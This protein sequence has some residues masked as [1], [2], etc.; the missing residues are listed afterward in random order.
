MLENTLGPIVEKTCG[1][2]DCWY[3]TAG[4]RPVAGCGPASTTTPLPRDG[5]LLAS[6]DTDHP[7]IR[8]SV[9]DSPNGC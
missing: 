7:V 3:D 2:A 6:S 4:H 9:P 8:Q 5:D 1:H